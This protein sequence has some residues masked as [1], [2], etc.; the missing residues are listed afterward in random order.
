MELQMLLNRLKV[1]ESSLFILEERKDE[2]GIERT[3]EWIAETKL[4]IAKLKEKI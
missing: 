1:L 3:K 2:K 4:A